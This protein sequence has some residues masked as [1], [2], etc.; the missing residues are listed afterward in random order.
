MSD[1][2]DDKNEQTGL[3]MNP[4]DNAVLDMLREGR[5]TPRLVAET[6]DYSRQNVSNRL[7]RLVEH[8][9]VRKVTRGLYELVED[10][11]SEEERDR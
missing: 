2:T 5:V 1:G 7:N 9:Y 4:T 3:E 6:Y 10:P 11:R 8:G